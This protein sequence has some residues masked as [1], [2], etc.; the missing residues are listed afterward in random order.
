MAE[1]RLFKPIVVGNFTLKHRIVL[2]PLTRLRANAQHV[3]GD[4]AVEYYKQR[5]SVPGTLLI[6]EAITVAPEAGGKPHVPGIWSEAQISAWKKANNS[7][8]PFPSLVA[9]II[10]SFTLQITDAVHEQGSFIFAQLRAYGRSADPKHL[11]T[12]NPDFPYVS[13][14][15]A[16]LPGA[17][18]AP[19]PLTIDGEH[20]SPLI[21]LAF[22][23]TDRP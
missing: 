21:H 7:I 11:R 4:I 5:A 1:S 14:S 20:A 19:R 8:R 23:F 10:L 22:I 18:E 17:T 16:P 2:A 6:S 3:H 13:A 9:Q 15:D 12:E